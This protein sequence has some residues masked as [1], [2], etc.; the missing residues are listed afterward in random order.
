MAHQRT[1][2]YG[3]TEVVSV[4]CDRPGCSGILRRPEREINWRRGKNKYGKVYCGKACACLA[5]PEADVSP[6]RYFPKM[7]IQGQRPGK[8]FKADRSGKS[9]PCDIVAGCGAPAKMHSF[10]KHACWGHEKEMLAFSR[11]H[12]TSWAMSYSLGEDRHKS[13]VDNLFGGQEPEAVELRGRLIEP[14]D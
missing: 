2:K 7:L 6:T 1:S 8:R 12:S 5:R 11:E 3:S 10:G 13:G 4:P 9:I 14:W